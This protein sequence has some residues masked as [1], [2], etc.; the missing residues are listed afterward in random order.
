MADDTRNDELRLQLEEAMS[1]H[2]WSQV[3]VATKTSITQPTISRFLQ[4]GGLSKS[5]QDKVQE[6]IAG[7]GDAA[8]PT[9]QEMRQA[10]RLYRY[11]RRISEEGTTFM[12]REPN[13]D[14]KALLILW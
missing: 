14:E 11:L 10:V 5:N 1:L 2:G 9:S 4:G 3:D 7:E 13:G 12:L 6:L 8:M